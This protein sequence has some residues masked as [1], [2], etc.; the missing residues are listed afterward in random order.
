S[1]HAGERGSRETDSWHSM[2]ESNVYLDASAPTFA[3]SIRDGCT[4]WVNHG[5]Q[6]HKAK[7]AGGKV[8][9]VRVKLITTWIVSLGEILVTKS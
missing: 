3:H 1:A 5:H 9:S 7:F 2:T 6:P 4:R 8:H